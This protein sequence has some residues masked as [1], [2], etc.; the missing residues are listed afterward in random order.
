MARKNRLSEVY[1]EAQQWSNR[2]ASSIRFCSWQL[3]PWSRS[4]TITVLGKFDSVLKGFV[5]P[6]IAVVKLWSHHCTFCLLKLLR[7][8]S[9][10][11]ATQYN[12]YRIQARTNYS[13]FSFKFFTSKLWESIPVSLK[14]LPPNSF[15]AHYKLH[16]LS[17][18][19]RNDI[20][21][22]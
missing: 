16:L 20:P 3:C 19:Q 2:S 12:Y 8:H 7:F 10:R 14:L 15:R 9:T 6:N 1:I 5:S 17:E 18:Q 22:R 21:L 13:K 11:Y 4:K